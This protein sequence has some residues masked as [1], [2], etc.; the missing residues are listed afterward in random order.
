MP[1]QPLARGTRVPAASELDR[2]LYYDKSQREI[3]APSA[4]EDPRL[5]YMEE[6]RRLDAN[7]LKLIGRGIAFPF[8]FTEEEKGVTRL[9]ESWGR[10]RISQSIFL[11]LSTRIG[12][13]FFNPLFGSRL[14][15]LVHEPYDEVLFRELMSETKGAVDRWEPRIETTQVEILDDEGWWENS[16]VG[17]NVPYVLK[18]TN[19]KGNYV[20]PFTL[21]GEPSI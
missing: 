21:S 9:S 7:L 13:R 10:N 8:E 2:A 4:V 1:R 20:F 17:I 16:Q 19:R 14:P 6:S 15:L 18:N 5:R 3:A 12:E 11:I